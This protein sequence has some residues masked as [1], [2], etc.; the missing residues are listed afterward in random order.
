MIQ[1][2]V[3]IAYKCI[4]DNFRQN[5]SFFIKKR[6][7]LYQPRPFCKKVCQEINLLKKLRTAIYNVGVVA[8][9]FIEQ[10]RGAALD[11]LLKLGFVGS[12]IR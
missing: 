12:I 3:K 8:N 9:G 2:S 4:N 5:Y 11:G 7:G 6:P 1:R 10:E